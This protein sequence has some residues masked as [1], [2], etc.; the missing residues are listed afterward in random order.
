MFPFVSFEAARLCILICSS[1]KITVVPI[2]NIG[3]GMRPVALLEN[4]RAIA[5]PCYLLVGIF[6]GPP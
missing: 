6:E 5:V 1:T 3:F 4:P 2:A